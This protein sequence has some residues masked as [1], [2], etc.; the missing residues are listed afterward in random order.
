MSGGECVGDVGGNT[1]Q[2]RAV[3]HHGL[4]AGDE[5]EKHHVSPRQIAALRRIIMLMQVQ[6]VITVDILWLGAGSNVQR[7]R[8]RQRGFRLKC[9]TFVSAGRR[10]LGGKEVV[11]NANQRRMLHP[12]IP[13]DMTLTKDP[14]TPTIR[15]RKQVFSNFRVAIHM[16]LD[17]LMDGGKLAV[18][19]EAS[20]DDTA[21]L[22]EQLDETLDVLKRPA[23]DFWSR[24]H[25]VAGQSHVQCQVSAG[26]EDVPGSHFTRT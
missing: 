24:T 12:D 5:H 22:A 7:D 25:A 15:G 18:R 9:G 6:V 16:R 19:G 10:D 21:L 4:D 1:D 14:S 3:L 17:V 23:R 20:R 13:D 26:Q 2:G 11:Q 8:K